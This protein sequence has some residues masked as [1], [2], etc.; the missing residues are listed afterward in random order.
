MAGAKS[1]VLDTQVGTVK[2]TIKEMMDKKI[3]L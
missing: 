1:I 3:L 2:L